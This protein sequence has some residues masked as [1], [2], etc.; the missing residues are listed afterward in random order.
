MNRLE[1]SA[2]DFAKVLQQL[3]SKTR[4]Q[5]KLAACLEII[6]LFDDSS[7]ETLVLQAK[8]HLLANAGANAHLCEKLHELSESYDAKY[9]SLCESD[10]TIES[11][12]V[13]YFVRARA[14]SALAFACES[15]SFESA[16]NAIYE[17]S[18]TF[19]KPETLFDLLRR[20]FGL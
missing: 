14:L 2:P 1:T 5:V 11:T 13:P 7:D 6:R 8:E 17:V 15:D 18:Y 10:T 20:N 19:E 9:F 16:A 12:Y 3:S 4:S